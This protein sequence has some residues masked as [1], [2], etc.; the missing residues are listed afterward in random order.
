M[1]KPSTAVASAVGSVGVGTVGG[2]RGADGVASLYF[3]MVSW[4]DPVLV[5]CRTN[6][7]QM[8]P[9]RQKEKVKT[10]SNNPEVV[11]KV[12]IKLSIKTIHPSS[13]IKLI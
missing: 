4:I 13:S 9:P 7:R 5:R 1:S 6:T 10:S 3:R 2:A 8:Y 12:K 11:L